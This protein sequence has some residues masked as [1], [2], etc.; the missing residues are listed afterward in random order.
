MGLYGPG[1]GLYGKIE[2]G[3]SLFVK[4]AVLIARIPM[5]YNHLFPC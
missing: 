4:R 2:N 5:F 1:L 3:F